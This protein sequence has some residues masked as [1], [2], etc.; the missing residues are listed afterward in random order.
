M[1]TAIP[2][3]LKDVRAS[4]AKI[5]AD[6]DVELKNIE[7]AKGR[8]ALHQGSRKPVA[9]YEVVLAKQHNVEPLPDKA[10][11]KDIAGETVAKVVANLKGQFGIAQVREG[12]KKVNPALTDSA[13]DGAFAAVAP[14]LKTITAPK[15]RRLG[16]YENKAEKPSAAKTPT[17]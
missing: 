14:A 10:K 3:P 15:G 8:I 6:I 11:L 9:A 13:I 2:Q 1:S 12:V 5:D 17:K 4:L 7:D 16:V